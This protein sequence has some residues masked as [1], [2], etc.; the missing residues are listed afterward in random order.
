M[1]NI[2]RRS[3][4]KT[5]PIINSADS[6]QIRQRKGA[7]K[8]GD[9]QR[10]K[11]DGHNQEQSRKNEKEPAERDQQGFENRDESRNGS[12]GDAHNQC[13]NEQNESHGKCHEQGHKPCRD[14]QAQLDQQVN[15]NRTNGWL[16]RKKSPTRLHEGHLIPVHHGKHKIHDEHGQQTNRYAQQNHEG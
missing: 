5:K 8:D 2:S 9:R 12:P 14:P 16:E 15:R 4:G 3:S 11:P 1:W 6:R 13:H 10:R 7:E